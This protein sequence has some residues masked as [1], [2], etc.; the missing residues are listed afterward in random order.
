MRNQPQNDRRHPLKITILGVARPGTWLDILC[1]AATIAATALPVGASAAS[2][3]LVGSSTKVCQLTGETDWASGQPTA[4][5]TWSQFGLAGVDL[6][7]PVESHA[8][9][10][11]FLFGDAFPIN[12]PPGSP[13]SLPADDALGWTARTAVP[14]ATTCLDLQL[15]TTAPQSFAHPTVTP[16]IQQGSFN[17]PSG[18]VYL[19]KTLYGFFWTDHCVFPSFLTPNPAAPLTR[20]APSAL[21]A[22][23][24]ANNSVG[25]SVLARAMPTD[26][27]A[28]HGPG[29][30]TK[31]EPQMPSGFVYVSAAAEAAVVVGLLDKSAVKMR[32]IPVFGAAR[33]RASIPYLAMAPEATFDDPTTWMFF[34]GRVGTTPIWFTRKEWESAHAANGGWAPPLGAEIYDATQMGERR[35]G[36]HSVTWNAALRA[37]LLVYNCGIDVIE[38]RTAPEP[39]GPW[40]APTVILSPTHDPSVVCTLIMS[41]SGC[42]GHR[43][44]VGG[45]FYASFVMNRFTQDVTAGGANKRATIYWLVSTWNPYNVVVMQS[46]LELV[47]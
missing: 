11:Y 21:C 35:V 4:A 28:F 34:A 2:L 20:P 45:A 36:E 30:I 47:P 40:S 32:A 22:E 25:R 10:L 37:W 24:P 19:N 1:V 18:G 7:F 44:G 31:I 38:A 16:A 33:Y 41:P 12:H 26:P 29:L 9:P 5:H 43:S 14:D 27:V 3:S 23:I 39:W 6:G 42:P 13:P 17:V 46:T 15:A 8:G